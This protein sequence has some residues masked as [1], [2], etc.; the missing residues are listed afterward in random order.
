MPDLALEE[1]TALGH[2]KAQANES[3][4]SHD[5]NL[6]A[7][8]MPDR[9]S[10][11]PNCPD[12]M[13][14]HGPFFLEIFAGKAG[15]TE[16]VALQGTPVLPP[17]DIEVSAMVVEPFDVVDLD[18]WQ[19]VVSYATARLIFFAHCGTPCNTYSSA[20]QD[21]GGP[22]PLRSSEWPMGLPTLSEFNAALVF[23]GNVFLFKSVEL[24]S[25]VFWAGGDFS[26][27]N[28]LL[29]LLFLTDSMQQLSRDTRALALDF[30]QCAFGAPSR[31]PTRLLCST[32]LLHDVQVACPGGH[33]HIKLKGKVW[34]ATQQRM[35][36]KTKQ[37][38]IYPWALCATIAQAVASLA[39]DPTQHLHPSFQLTVPAA[40]RKRP[41]GSEKPWVEH[42][43]AQSAL[44][45]Q[46]A[47][48]QLKRAAAKPLLSVEME[49][50]VAVQAALEVVH[51]FSL[52]VPL[53]EAE[54]SALLN[55]QRPAAEVVHARQQALEYW[56]RQA[57]DLLPVS[58]ARIE[59]LPDPA[60]RK[61][62]LGNMDGSLPQLGS[63]C[64]VALYEA[65]LQ[66]CKSVDQT[67]PTFL[68]QGFPL[69]VKLLLLDDGLHIRR[70]RKLCQYKMLLIGPGFCARRSLTG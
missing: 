57:H 4:G 45:A 9:W 17:I 43:Q 2:P 53:T 63:V 48:Y 35:V 33:K 42:R 62:L 41:V 7:Q 15:I 19:K 30:D 36:F 49:P 26:I 22:P 12:D 23:L 67:L 31:K 20:R 47:G 59:G 18:R 11:L 55:L 27:E 52:E 14:S 16:A 50:G 61:L 44:R 60:L 5:P 38:Q 54:E 34:D 51:P 46:W 25:L 56:Q 37:A 66:A 65:M 39:E 29:S 68:L 21:D 69:L 3:S 8:A 58:L 24:C 70:P 32:E 6:K 10:Q 13:R 40:E 1:R 28:P 64:H